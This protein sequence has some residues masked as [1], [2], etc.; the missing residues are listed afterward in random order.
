[1]EPNENK[2]L[3]KPIESNEAIE[4]N[5]DKSFSEIIKKINFRQGKYMLPALLYL[6]VLFVGYFVCDMFSFEPEET[7]KGETTQ[8][9]NDNLPTAQYKGDGIGGKYQSVLE[10]YGK[11]TDETAVNSVEGDSAKLEQYDSGY[12][13]AEIASIEKNSR[14]QIDAEQELRKLQENLAKAQERATTSVSSADH[15]IGNTAEE[16]ATLQELQSALANARDAA[17]VTSGTLPSSVRDYEKES[18]KT[19]AQVSAA[20][21][22]MEKP[23]TPHN[24]QAVTAIEE[25]Q[26]VNEVVKKKEQSSDYFNTIASK[27]NEEG[28]LIKAIIDE[29]VKAVDGSRV[30]L[31]LLDD[32]EIQGTTIK[33]GTYLYAE[34]SG[35]GQQRVKGTV[36][37]LLYDDQLLKINLSIYDTDGLEGLYVPESNFRELTKDVA[38]N[39][40]SGGGG[41]FFNSST[42]D[43]LLQMGYQTLQNSYSK[44]TNAISKNI[45]K[46]KAKLK[47][48]TLVYLINSKE[49]KEKK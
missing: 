17:T 45:R 4:A 28:N 44:I 46:N 37:S 31:R 20:L 6:P 23:V 15:S 42:S 22:N 35:F 19:T 38:S 26:P 48:G 18:E 27:K 3:N 5:E 2:E 43:N 40:L 13:D 21:K 16:D 9:L 32:V 29:E 12:T 33:K 8:Y 30:R 34:M 25:E 49:Q 14:Q 7:P 11:I 1:M 10:N 39:A 36:S 47:Y 41:S 24:P